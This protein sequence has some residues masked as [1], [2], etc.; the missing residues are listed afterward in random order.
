MNVQLQGTKR[1]LLPHAMPTLQCMQFHKDGIYVG[2]T[3]RQK[4]FADTNMAHPVMVTWIIAKDN[5]H[6]RC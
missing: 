4:D 1:T 5:I 6:C 3:S 2:A